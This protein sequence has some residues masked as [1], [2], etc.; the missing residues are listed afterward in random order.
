MKIAHEHPLSIAGLVES[1]TDYNYYI[2]TIAAQDEKYFKHACVD[3]KFK[4][5]DCG[6]F[7]EG[8]PMADEDY[9][10]YIKAIRPTEFVVPDHLFEKDKTLQAAKSWL[11][12]IEVE[13]IEATPIGVVQ[14]RTLEEQFLCYRELTSMFEKVAIPYDLPVDL[15]VDRE[16]VRSEYLSDFITENYTESERVEAQEWSNLIMQQG[17]LYYSGI[18]LTK[19][20]VPRNG[21]VDFIKFLVQTGEL[22]EDRKHHFLGVDLLFEF[23]QYQ[24][25]NISLEKIV[26]TIDTSSPV[27]HGLK[28]IPYSK[29]FGLLYKDKQKMKTLI[30]KQDITQETFIKYNI[31]AFRSIVNK[32]F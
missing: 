19:I 2:S 17:V 4:I 8:F 5:L 18:D 26:D 10:K 30:Q 9:L 3:T 22:R 21:R 25:D 14:G 15:S 7:E 29:Q 31:A 27:L 13:K 1:L 32:N 20:V 12:L 28:E 11:K 16:L 6:T 23:L 24:K